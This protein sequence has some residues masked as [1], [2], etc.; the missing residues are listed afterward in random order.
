MLQCV[1]NYFYSK[2]DKNNI[3]GFYFLLP[4]PEKNSALKRLNMFLR[5]MIRDGDVDLGL[6]DFIDKSELVIP[7]DTH[8][9]RLSRQWGILSRNSND[10]KSAIEVTNMLKNFDPK[11]PVKYD[12][13][14]FGFGV[15]N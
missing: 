6:W 5:W 11:D 14:L 1:V 12:F 9:A 10:Y 8:V 2:V 13:A 3:E 4:N 7:L 15:N